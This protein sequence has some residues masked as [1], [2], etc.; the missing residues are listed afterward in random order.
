MWPSAS[1]SNL[2]GIPIDISATH[3][4]EI[5]KNCRE[6]E[7][8]SAHEGRIVFSKSRE[9]PT[10]ALPTSRYRNGQPIQPIIL[11]YMDK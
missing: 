8:V 5:A 3:Y 1:C 2:I 4:T 10:C 6:V 11:R 9:H 7:H